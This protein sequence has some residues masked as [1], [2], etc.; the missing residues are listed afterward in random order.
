MTAKFGMVL[1]LATGLVLRTALAQPPVGA[2]IEG[3]VTDAITGEG[4]RK[5]TVVLRGS[6]AGERATGPVTAMA[7]TTDPGGRYVFPNLAAGRYRLVAER[8]GYVSRQHADGMLAVGDDTHIKDANIALMPQAA[9][10]GRVLD[11]DGEPVEYAVVTCLKLSYARGTRQW[12][13]VI[14]SSTNDLGEYRIHGLSP[15]RYIISATHSTSALAGSSNAEEFYA[16]T[17]YPGVALSEMAAPLPLNPGTVL[18]GVD[19]PLSR[20]RPVAVRGRVLSTVSGQPLEATQVR[21]VPRGG[22]VSRAVAASSR[23]APDG[24]FSMERVTPGAYWLVAENGN[25]PRTAGRVAI[26]AGG[27]GVDNAAVTLTAGTEVAG[28]IEA[29]QCA[30]L[31]PPRLVAGLDPVTQV[32]GF[33]TVPRPPIAADGTFTWRAVLPGSYQFRLS[34]HPAGCYVK[35]VRLGAADVTGGVIEVGTETAG[36][37]AVTLANGAGVVEGSVE[38]DRHQPAASATVVL[39][40]EGDRAARSFYYASTTTGSSG[41]FSLTRVIPG[42]YRAYAFDLIES[43]AYLDAE[44]MKPYESSGVRVRVAEGGKEAVSLKQI[45]SSQ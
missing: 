6:A 5:A 33:G 38:D 13:A 45:R 21:L 22:A 27:A 14:S 23:V 9:I 19:V 8:S 43:G 1:V 15:G 20:V 25:A 37:L 31:Q 7:A 39:V 36:P 4:L 44:Y 10:T 35:S 2:S 40:P 29:G 28:V 18:R 34:G 12:T 26:D 30:G 11:E 24:S 42:E 17:F 3:R 41:Q 32:T 16:P